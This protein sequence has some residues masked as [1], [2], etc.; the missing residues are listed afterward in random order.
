MTERGC[1]P[2]WSHGRALEVLARSDPGRLRGLGDA[3]IPSLGSVEVVESRTVLVMVPMR[4]PVEGRAFLLGEVLMAE[5]HVR[6]GGID[7]YG[8]RR[9]RDLEASMAMALA[10]LALASG[11]GHARVEA[12]LA[13]EA[14]AQAQVDDDAMRRVEATRVKM[15]TF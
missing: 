4:D 13:D 3:L 5:A 2:G 11:P 14:A 8:L 9:G 12:F 15:E 7:G 6:A 1:P 10:D